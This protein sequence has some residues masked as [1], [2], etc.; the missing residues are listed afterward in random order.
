MLLEDFN[1]ADSDKA[2]AVLQP[3]LD[4]ERWCRE[5]LAARPFASVDALLECAKNAAEP[6]TSSEVDAA[7]AH[8]PRIGEKPT[9]TG[10]EAS[11]ARAE[12]SGVDPSDTDVL[13]ALAAGNAEYE[14]K[15]NQVFLIRAAGRSP[16]E[17]LDVLAA[18]MKNTAG[19][20]TVIVAQ[21]LREIA[22]LRLEGAMST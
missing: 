1:A 14:K 21:Q 12:Q 8:H 10:T 13:A 2:L 4:I 18:R 11:L 19:E 9:G 16:Q 17:I 22:L 5:I 3:C 7:M 15:F 20:E 6:F